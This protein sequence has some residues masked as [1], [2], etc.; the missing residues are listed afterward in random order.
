AQYAALP[1]AEPS[2]APVRM[3]AAAPVATSS[4][5]RGGVVAMEPIPDGSTPEGAARLAES[6]SRATP[7]GGEVLEDGR[8]I[9]ARMDP[10]PD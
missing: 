10:I 2:A 7:S 8:I 9:V 5:G 6:A 4:L 3:A 1:P